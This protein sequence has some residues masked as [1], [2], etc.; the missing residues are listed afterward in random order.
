MAWKQVQT[1][2]H[3]LT[4]RAG[5]PEGDHFA[6]DMAHSFHTVRPFLHKWTKVPTDYDDLYQQALQEM[7]Q[8]DFEA[9]WRLVTTW[10]TRATILKELYSGGSFPLGS[11]ATRY[12]TW[13][14]CMSEEVIRT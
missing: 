1:R 2:E 4:Y 7:Q 6:Q 5:T 8:P 11:S 14:K 3:L 12:G 9:T 10:G 13:W